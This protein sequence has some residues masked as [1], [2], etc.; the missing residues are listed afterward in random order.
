MAEQLRGPFKKFVSKN[1]NSWRQINYYQRT[2]WETFCG[3]NW[4]ECI[5]LRCSWRKSLN[6]QRIRNGTTGIRVK[7]TSFI[8]HKIHGNTILQQMKDL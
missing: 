7:G 3:E 4:F 5:T 2:D 1:Y 6:W 8:S